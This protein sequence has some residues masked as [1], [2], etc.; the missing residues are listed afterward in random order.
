M[1]IICAFRGYE[2]KKEKLYYARSFRLNA[3]RVSP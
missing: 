2:W 3:Y 1:K